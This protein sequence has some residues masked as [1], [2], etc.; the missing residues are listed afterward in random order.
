MAGGAAVVFLIQR[1]PWQ[2]TKRS[3]IYLYS[4]AIGLNSLSGVHHQ[5]D[6]ELLGM[7]IAT[8]ETEKAL[9]TLKDFNIKVQPRLL[10]YSQTCLSLCC[11]PS[12]QLTLGTGLIVSRVQ[13]LF[14]HDQLHFAPGALFATSVDLLTHYNPKLLSQISDNFT[15]PV[16]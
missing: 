3:A 6:S 16:S 13:E 12:I 1:Y 10:S 2:G 9:A 4:A 14:G 11:K 8:K 7:S 5:I 15:A